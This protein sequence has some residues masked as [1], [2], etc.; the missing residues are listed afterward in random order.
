MEPT[1]DSTVLQI[2]GAVAQRLGQQRFNLWFKNSTR[3]ALTDGFLEI[4][5]P[6]PF[7][8]GWIE[9]HF[10]DQIV[11]AAEEITG[12][13]LQVSFSVNPTL[14]RNLK[15][16]QLDHQARVVNTNEVRSRLRNGKQGSQT[17]VRKLRG[18]LDGFVVGA[19]N[20]MAFSAVQDVLATPGGGY[21]PLFIHGGCGLGKTHL[22]QGLA[23][24]LDEERPELK[25][26]LLSG[27]EFTNQFLA[28]LRRSEL[29]TFRNKFRH[30]DV[31]ILDDVHFLANKKATQ[32][33]FLHTFNAIEG[34]GKQVVMASDSHPKLIGEFSKSLVS[35]F[36]AGMVV[37]IDPPELETRCKI[38]RHRAA[39]MK[40]DVPEPVVEYIAERM[41]TNVRE[42]EG[43]LL[44][45]AAFSN[46]VG[47]PI[48]MGLAK[49][50]LAEHLSR[51]ST[52]IRLSDI[53]SVVATFFGLSP[54]DLHTSRKARTVALARAIAM[55]LARKHT[56][57]S[58][59]E[60]GRYMGNKNHSTVI[61]AC[62]RIAKV[63]E[64]EGT[65]CWRTPTGRCEMPLATLM[66]RLEEELAR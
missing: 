50:A 30:L 21:N 41:D 52:I 33:E 8:G 49:Q 45:L 42:L 61:L 13:H 22:L 24:G 34:V 56:D 65:V 28:A 7:I 62:R 44:K 16:G 26:A 31:L 20:Q 18:R 29:E 3:F 46:V 12:R 32:E 38:L 51:A 19:S 57:M 36:V 27:E 17:P 10:T 25:W 5:V 15:K 37:K 60:I 58:F 47:Q 43:A 35:R 14:M 23:N 54:A 2:R 6:N 55:F 64:E 48:T 63:L 11:E 59:P 1:A 39:Q 53:E 66:A 40:R 9:N 4:D